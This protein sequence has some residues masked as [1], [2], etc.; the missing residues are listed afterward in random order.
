[1]RRGFKFQGKDVA[2]YRLFHNENLEGN[3]LR[4]LTP[5]VE[6]LGHLQSQRSVF[7]WLDSE[8]YFELQGFLDNTGK[9]D[10]LTKI[11]LS[12]QVVFDGLRDLAA[13]G[14]DHRLLFPDLT[15]AA[16]FANTRWDIF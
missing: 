3:G 9:G 8:I 5:L 6:E 4:V 16:L 7:T 13:H 2:I 11:I 15:G 12:D 1:L 10:L 14:I